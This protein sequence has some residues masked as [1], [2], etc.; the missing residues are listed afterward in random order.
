MEVFRICPTVYAGRDDVMSG[1]GAKKNGQRWNDPGVPAAYFG[2]SRALCALELLVHLGD[3]SVAPAALTMIRI[4]LNDGCRFTD[5]SVPSY[6]PVD[7][8]NRED[9]TRALGTRWLGTAYNHGFWIPSAIIPEERNLV[10]NPNSD[11]HNH[12]NVVIEGPFVFDARLL[13]R[14]SKPSSS[15][16]P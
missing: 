15:G 13:N 7:W 3:V 14:P 4:E 9:L 16:T 1:E 8:R 10:I 12:V 6:L 5:H 11:I 2:S